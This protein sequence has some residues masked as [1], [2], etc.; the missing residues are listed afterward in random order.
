VLK[1]RVCGFNG[2]IAVLLQDGLRNTEVIKDELNRSAAHVDLVIMGPLKDQH[3]QLLTATLEKKCVR[4]AV[5]MNG[6]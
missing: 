1:L 5:H 2:V 3:V 6:E 4:Q